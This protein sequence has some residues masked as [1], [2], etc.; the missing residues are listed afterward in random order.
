MIDTSGSMNQDDRI[1]LARK[2]GMSVLKTLTEHDYAT[3]ID[4]NTVANSWGDDLF[5]KPMTDANIDPENDN[6]AAAYIDRLGPSGGTNFTAA[7]QKAY[8]IF[9]KSTQVG[10]NSS[11]CL[12]AI[13]FLTDGEATLDLDLVEQKSAELGFIVF[14]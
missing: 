10:T 11:G 6:S 4:F 5:L 2:A 9:S 1:G 7:F 8:D 14:S 3:V 13:L 12:K